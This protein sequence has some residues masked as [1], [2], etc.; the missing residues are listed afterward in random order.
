[1][2]QKKKKK[3]KTVSSTDLTVQLNFWSMTL[4]ICQEIKTRLTE[5]NLNLTTVYRLADIMHSLK[6]CRVLFF[7]Q[8]NSVQEVKLWLHALLFFSLSLS[9]LTIQ[10]KKKK[11]KIERES[12]RS[13]WC[14]SNKQTYCVLFCNSLYIIIVFCQKSSKSWL[15]WAFILHECLFLNG[16]N[17]SAV[18]FCTWY[19]YYK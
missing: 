16:R 12:Q 2:G 7:W 19:I 13:S 14:L 6:C 17:H 3:A 5:I 8:L 10:K 15:L 9:A 1:M 18:W 11:K 4:E